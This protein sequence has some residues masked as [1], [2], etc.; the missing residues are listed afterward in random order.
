MAR[1]TFTDMRTT[2]RDPYGFGTG[3]DQSRVQP[4]MATGGRPAAYALGAL[5]NLQQ[6]TRRAQARMMGG[7]GGQPMSAADRARQVMESDPAWVLT[8]GA[9]EGQRNALLARLSPTGG[10]GTS[11]G[12]AQMA[13]LEG[14]MVQDWLNQRRNMLTQDRRHGLAAMQTASNIRSQQMAR[15]AQKAN[16]EQTKARTAQMQADTDLRNRLTRLFG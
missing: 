3:F 6:R 11:Q 13:N 10:H 14:Q 7:A 1:A 2:L 15:K 9:R 8:Q 4:R 5:T 12:L 16:I